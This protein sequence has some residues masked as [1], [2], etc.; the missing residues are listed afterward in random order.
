[1]KKLEKENERKMVE[2]NDR[3]STGEDVLKVHLK[4]QKHQELAE[5][6]ERTILPNH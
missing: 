2:E 5:R 4:G 3:K 1:M 6:F